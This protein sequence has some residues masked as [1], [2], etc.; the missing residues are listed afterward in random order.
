VVGATSALKFFESAFYQDDIAY[1]PIGM[2][3]MTARVVNILN[4]LYLVVTG[5]GNISKINS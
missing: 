4:G 5:W 3:R 2:G 1:F